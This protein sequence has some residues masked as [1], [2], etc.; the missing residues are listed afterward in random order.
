MKR[1]F[2][3]VFS[4]LLAFVSIERG[5]TSVGMIQTSSGISLSLKSSGLKTDMNFGKMP[6]YFIENRGQM[7]ERVAY[8]VQG[9][10][11]SL[12][13]TSE[14]MTIALSGNE[15]GKGRSKTPDL[16][17]PIGREREREKIEAAPESRWVVKLDFVDANPAARPTGVEKTEAVISYFKGKPE[18]WKTGLPTYSKIIY[19]DLW[20]G[21]DLLYSGTVDRMKYEFIVHPGADPSRIRLAY[22]GADSVEVTEEGR[23]AVTTPVGGFEDDVPVAWQDGDRGKAD[24][25]A[26]YVLQ[27]MEK[28]A[29]G[30]GSQVY[31]FEVGEYDRS[32]PLVLDPAVLVYCGYIGGTGWDEA[33]GIAVDG[34]RNA[35]IVGYAGSTEASFPVVVGP[36][37]TGGGD[38]F[39]AKVN[40]SGTALVYCGYIGGSSYD[41]GYGIAVD[42]LGNAYI[43]GDTASAEATF[44]VVS[45]PGLIFSDQPPDAFVAKVNAAGT[46]LVYCG[47]I[48]GG[49]DDRGLS[50]AV[51]GSGNA[52]VTGW[53][54]S[55]E[56][57]FPVVEGPDLT[58][59]GGEDVFVAKVNATGTALDYCGYIGSSG[60]DRGY[61]IAVDNLGNAYVTGET[62]YTDFP[63][64]SGPDLTQNGSYD[65]FVAKVNATGT[66]LVYCG[67]IGGSGYDRG[68]GIDV[69]GS[70]NAYVAGETRSAED[71]FPVVAG[72]DLT[73]N[74]PGLDRADAFVAKI[75]PTGTALIYCGYIGGVDHETALGVAVDG[76]GNA[77]IAGVTYSS[78]ATFPVVSGPDLTYNDSGIPQEGD[79]FV[80]KVDSS[81][82]A[83]VYCGYIGSYTEEVARG[84]AVDDFGAAYVVGRTSAWDPFFP[85]VTGPDLT[86]YGRYAAFVAKIKEVPV[87]V[88]APNGGEIWAA[89]SVRNIT[90]RAIGTIANVKL[91]YS[92]DRGANWTTI[93][94]STTNTGT[95]AWTVPDASS[96]NGLV[97][98]SDAANAAAFDVSDAAFTLVGMSITVTAPNGGEIWAAG[99]MH[100][101]TWTTTGTIANVK[102]E[103][104]TDGGANWTTIIASSLNVG[105]FAWQW[106]MAASTN[107]RVRV[108]DASNPA[109]SD[110]S[111]ASFTI[112][113]PAPPTIRLS[114]I[115][116]DF[117][118][119]SGGVVT[120]SQSVIVSNT[121]GGTLNWS[122]H[123]S[124]TWL[125]VTPASGTGT[126]VI[127]MSVNPAGLAAGSYT[128]T[129]TVSDP[130][131]TNS[132]QAINVGLMVKAAGTVPFGSFDTPVEGTTGVT[133]AVPVTGWAMD[134]I[135]VVKVEI[136]RD[137]FAGETPGQWAIGEAIFVEGARPDIEAAFPTLPMN[138]KAGWGYM[139]LTN[140]LPAHGNGTYKLYAYATDKE[141]N[142]VLLGSKTITCSNATAVKPFGTI[143]TPTQGG[144][145]SGSLF[146]NFGWVL[147]PK[148][149]TVP[150]NGSTIDVYVDSV[151]V[152]NL[153]TAPNVYNQYRVDVATAFPGLNNTG[154]P[155]AGGPV[156]AYYLDTTTYPNGVHT[157]YWIAT[158]DGGQAD[159]IGSRYFSIVNTGTS[160]PASAQSINPEK[161]NYF[162]SLMNLPVSFE[163]LMAKRGFSF[164]PDPEVLQP[165]NYGT[166]HIEIKEVERVEIDLGKAKPIRG[167]HVVGEEL[168]SLPIGSTLDQRTGTFSWMPGPGFVGTYDLVFIKEGGLGITRRIPVKVTIRPKFES[169]RE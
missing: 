52:Y 158:D 114:K 4:F 40:A 156:G 38:A 28:A 6:V 166:L 24:V 136:L 79:A 50:I 154:A 123:S 112:F 31:G 75:N 126:A 13:F 48:G 150:K 157:I 74:N 86:W 119:Q 113:I 169:H 46:S 106:F 66:A 51:D 101:L 118:A 144:N 135:G 88:T 115:R 44:P 84:I 77:Y 17:G 96:V 76:S 89:G 7:D 127:Q 98:V 85:V 133:G 18:E 125:A 20:P 81:G 109:V 53:T 160:A 56:W 62:S 82:K 94:A 25:P 149:K 30:N 73:Y 1:R 70:G 146:V 12:Y 72:P 134:D 78:E 161:A 93:V 87:L 15:M 41:R 120:Q 91:Q 129:I 29:G 69:D 143:D 65:V 116:L 45:G 147:T 27:K 168:R 9:K 102:L 167:Y 43:T 64:V 21:I 36:D 2:I 59:N 11:K 107:C 139:M 104:S 80:A 138:Y 148:P 152:G 142:R 103:Y 92:T 83:L 97:R 23:L 68:Y 22:R 5:S 49:V 3:C 26:A 145:A 132:P 34:S 35:Y 117:G 165:D 10:D 61:G 131:A 140:M 155:G 99:S 122:A 100:A 37:L 16:S 105:E 108:S 151:K 60:N 33:S 8:Y 111:D 32:R 58:S 47:Y 128:G 163:P 14:G 124:Q 90:W 19:Q 137:N 153:A 164:K 95:Y 110:T 141:G 130:N 162:E 67:Y 121:G 57:L 55:P 63:V 159:G 71:T 39:V 42:N 54:T